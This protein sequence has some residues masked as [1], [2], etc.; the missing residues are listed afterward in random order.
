MYELTLK[1]RVGIFLGFLFLLIPLGGG[2]LYV[3]LDSL[4]LYFSF[5]P[6]FTFSSL[7]LYGFTMFLIVISLSFLSFPPVFLGRLASLSIQKNISLFIYICIF[8][9]IAVQIGFRFYFVSE[10]EH[11]GYIACRGIPSGWMPGMATHYV[12]DEVL[13]SKKDP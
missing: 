1:R 8:F 10:L 7:T 13:C 3:A 11:R 4:A 2:G 9:F 12:T 6:S 5:P